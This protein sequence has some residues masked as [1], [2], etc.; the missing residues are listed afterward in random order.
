MAAAQP[1]PLSPPVAVQGKTFELQLIS[2]ANP[3]GHGEEGVK[4]TAGCVV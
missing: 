4:E 1:S 3:C 2:V